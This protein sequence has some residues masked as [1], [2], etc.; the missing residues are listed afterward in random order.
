MV[1]SATRMF[2]LQDPRP[3]LCAGAAR[4]RSQ[5]SRFR[6]GGAGTS[7]EQTQSR[8]AASLTAGSRTPGGTQHS[9]PR[10]L[11]AWGR[12]PRSPWRGDRARPAL[13][14]AP[15]SGW[16]PRSTPSWPRSPRLPR[17]K[18]SLLMTCKSSPNSL[19]R[20]AGDLCLVPSHNPPQTATVQLHP[21]QIALMMRFP[22]ER[23]SKPTRRAA[24]ISV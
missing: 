22:L 6:S 18:S 15:G 14:T 10:L 19:L 13:L 12:R 9:L 7:G 11:P 1:T 21:I 24:A 2:S 8:R 5:T 3:T 20:L 16:Q 4:D 17:S 23:S